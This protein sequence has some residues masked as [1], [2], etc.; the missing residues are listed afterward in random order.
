MF[1]LRQN[2]LNIQN[3]AVCWGLNA[4]IVCMYIFQ[5]LSLSQ[6]ADIHSV[7]LLG[8]NW[9][10]YAANELAALHLNICLTFTRA[11]RS[12]LSEFL[13]NPPPSPAPPV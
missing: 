1:I 6:T 2:L 4:L 8:T 13:W 12:M 10:A 3:N 9:L 11:F 5:V 7:K